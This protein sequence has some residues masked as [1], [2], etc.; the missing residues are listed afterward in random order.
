MP[1]ISAMHIS[2]ISIFRISSLWPGNHSYLSFLAT[3]KHKKNNQEIVVTTNVHGAN[4][5]LHIM[6]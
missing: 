3:T 1:G 4:T 2:Y 6:Y 5:V